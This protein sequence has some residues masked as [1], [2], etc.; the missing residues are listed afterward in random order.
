MGR[1]FTYE[2][3]E[4]EVERVYRSYAA[5]TARPLQNTIWDVRFWKVS[6]PK[7][8]G[9]SGYIHREKVDEVSESDLLEALREALRKANE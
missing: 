7:T 9:I 8:D 3:E 5:G 2:D 4:W 6:V 1:L